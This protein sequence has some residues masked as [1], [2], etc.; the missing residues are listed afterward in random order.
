MYQYTTETL[1]VIVEGIDFE[2]VQSFRVKIRGT[3][4]ELLKTISA[5]S[6]DVDA[7]HLTVDVPLTQ[8]ET[9]SLGRGFAQVQVRLVTDDGD[10]LASNKVK[11]EV[12]SVLD[13]VVI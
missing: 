8:E 12:N 11:H 2:Y 7:E 9:A 4:G 13:E 3:K 6:A 10:V 5:S 1:T